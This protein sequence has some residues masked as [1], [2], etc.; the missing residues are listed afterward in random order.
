MRRDCPPHRGP[1]L[2]LLGTASYY[3]GFVSLCVPVLVVL[4]LPLGLVAFWLAGRDLKQ[5]D[6]GGMD[7]NGRAEVELAEERAWGGM[8]L[9]LV[10]GF[11]C[12]CFLSAMLRL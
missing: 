12:C 2:L 7:P 11:Y 10:P 5:M 9:S 8:V 4:G 3:L 6:A 1:T